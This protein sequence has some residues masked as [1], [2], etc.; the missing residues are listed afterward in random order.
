MKV[1]VVGHGPSYKNY[2]FIRNFDGLILCTDVSA[3]DLIENKII[4]DYFLM[5][6]LHE[7]IVNYIDT[8]IPYDWV[9]EY[10]IRKKM[11]VIHQPRL[12]HTVTS[13]LG[14]MKMTME[15]F[16]A[17]HTNVG[18]YA[19]KYADSVIKPDEIHLIGLD[20]NGLDY[21]GNDFSELWVKQAREYL[22][23]RKGCKIIDHSGGNFP[24]L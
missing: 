21:D 2:E 5:S 24:C 1:L 10:Q 7:G 8:M 19:I 9:E 23:L 13:R 3:A 20:Y 18:L 16:D 22:R 12:I 11:K 14:R 4:P 17:G 15:V 6:E